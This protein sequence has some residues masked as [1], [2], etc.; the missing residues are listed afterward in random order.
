MS[1]ILDIQNI[2]EKDILQETDW[3]SNGYPT[4]L[5]WFYK[6]YYN[7]QIWLYDLKVT[8]EKSIKWNSFWD[9][10]C[11]RRGSDGLLVRKACAVQHKICR[12]QDCSKGRTGHAWIE[13]KLCS[14]MQ[15]ALQ[16]RPI[17]GTW[18][19]RYSGSKSVRV[20][21]R[22]VI[23]LFEAESAW[24]FKVKIWLDWLLS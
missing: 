6:N 12:R 20:L 21:F 9:C 10:R 14:I 16:G 18:S 13:W 2:V 3:I 22:S 1:N 8:M 23:S 4:I 15:E 17:V 5:H 24:L 11:Y 19:G 7:L